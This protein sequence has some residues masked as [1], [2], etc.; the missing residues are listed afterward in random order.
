M[1]DR[2]TGLAMFLA[3]ALPLFGPVALVSWRQ[4][5]PLA[6]LLVRDG[7]GT[8]PCV[9]FGRVS[10]FSH[11]FSARQVTT[12]IGL[13]LGQP[14]FLVTGSQVRVMPRELRRLTRYDAFSPPVGF[15]AVLLDLPHH[16]GAGRSSS[17]D[18]PAIKV[19][20]P[21][22]LGARSRVARWLWHAACETG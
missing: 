17:D 2:T 15:R 6:P 13:R 20:T 19:A 4:M 22:Q 14:H 9:G 3:F 12:L 5:L 16:L 1:D 10:V 7:L 11:R 21:Q 18:S 8:V